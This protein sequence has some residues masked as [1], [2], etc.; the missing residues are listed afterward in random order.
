MTYASIAEVWGGISGS[1]Q[2]STPMEKKI[3]PL[4]QQQIERKK[5]PRNQNALDWKSSEDLY[6]CTYGSHDCKSVFKANEKYNNEKKTIAAGMQ[7]Y[8]PGSPGPH[9]FT[10]LPQYPWYPW[11]RADY[12][13]YGPDVSRMW[14]SNPWAYNP[15]VAAQI[16]Q[17][18]NTHNVGP[19]T[20]IGQYEPQG[21]M[22]LPPNMNLNPQP[23]HLGQKIREDFTQPNG[24]DNNNGNYMLVRYSMIY[25][26]IFL[27]CIAIIL[28]IFMICLTTMNKSA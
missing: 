8:I 11:A 20:P 23:P 13:T 27:V 1:T 6:Q 9:N 28:C 24:N 22:P 16:Q 7:P 19:L 18:Q 4:H 21:F 5:A 10:Y 3:H 2:L 14:Y 17:Y 15:Q 25:L 26:V 12:L